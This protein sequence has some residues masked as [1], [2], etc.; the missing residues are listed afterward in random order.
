[1]AHRGLWPN[2][3]GKPFRHWE[4][5]CSHLISCRAQQSTKLASSP[6]QLMLGFRLLALLTELSSDDEPA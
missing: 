3:Q 4:T 2:L 5:I 1:M 6:Q